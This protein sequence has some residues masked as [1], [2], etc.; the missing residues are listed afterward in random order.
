[1]ITEKVD[2]WG[3]NNNM[4]KDDIL[5]VFGQDKEKEEDIYS[6]LVKGSIVTLTFKEDY[7]AFAINGHELFRFNDI[8]HGS[9]IKYRMSV[10]MY[11]SWDS[12]TLQKYSIS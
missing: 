5:K 10:E 3:Q 9:N 7:L 4:K 12:V 1:M 6:D 2:G 11:F 8:R